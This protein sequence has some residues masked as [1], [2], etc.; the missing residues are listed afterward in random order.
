MD[1]PFDP[2]AE[3][4]K[5]G[6]TKMDLFYGDCFRGLFVDFPKLYPGYSWPKHI[7]LWKDGRFVWLHDFD[8]LRMHAG[9]LFLDKMLPTEPRE[10][11]RVQWRVVHDE[12]VAL[13]SEIDS[14]VF[15]ELTDQEFIDLWKRFD[16]QIQKF[17]TYSCLP[18]LSNYGSSEILEERLRPSVATDQMASVLEVLTAPEGLSFYQEEEIDLAETNDMERHQLAYFWLRNGY[19]RIEVLPVSFFEERKN[20]LS[21]RI[22]EECMERL[23]I[24]REKKLK[25]QKQ[26]TIPA[27][28]MVLA[29]AIADGILWQD[30]RK[31]DVWIYLHY[32]DVMLDEVV[33]RFGFVKEDLLYL[34]AFEISELMIGKTP[35]IPPLERKKAFAFVIAESGAIEMKDVNIAREYWKVYVEP[36]IEGEV[37]EFR[38]VVASKGN[39]LVRGKVRIVL[40]PRNADSFVRGEILVTSMTTPEYVFLMKNAAAVI[41]DTGGLTS[42][43]AIVSRELGIPCIVGTKVATRVLK[44]GDMV[45]VD[46]QRGIVRKI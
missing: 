25:V 38:G 1:Y 35:A 18:E 29:E 44:D 20:E 34:F 8:E 36:P 45:E 32:R 15:S 27:D 5:W 26:Y 10:E 9:K 4:F 2:K 28:I 46:A 24:T 21:P 14:V 3:I 41:T 23:R 40:N 22:R 33:R 11:A 17:W 37:S 7:A 19:D 42:H 39:G 13:Q 12:L 16:S 6:P 30:V 43:A 31:K